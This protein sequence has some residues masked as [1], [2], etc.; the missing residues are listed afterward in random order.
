MHNVDISWWNVSETFNFQDWLTYNFSLLYIISHAGTEN[1][2]TYQVEVV[3][4]I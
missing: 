2:Q 3:I 1:T 4:L